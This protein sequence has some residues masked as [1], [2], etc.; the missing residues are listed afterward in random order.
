MWPC[1]STTCG[2]AARTVRQTPSTSTSKTRSHSS[3]EIGAP[4]PRSTA[5]CR[6]WPPPRR[7]RRSARPSR[8]PPPRSRAWSVTSAAIPIA[9]SP[10]RS[11]ASRASRGRGRRPRPRRPACASGARPRSRSPAPRRSPAPPFRSGRRAGM[12]RGSVLAPRISLPVPC[13]DSGPSIP[14]SPSPS[15]RRA[16]SRAGASATSSSA[17]W[18]TGMATRSGASTRGLPQPTAGPA[19][20]TSSPAS[21][22]T[23]IR[24]T[25]RCAATGCRARPAGTATASRRA[26]GREAARHLLEA[27]D[28]GLR[29]RR[30]QRALPGVRLRVR[31]GV[32]P[33]DRADR[34]LDRPRRPL[35]HPRQR[36][37]RVGLVV[38]AEAL[39]RRTASTRAT[40]SCPTARAAAPRSPPTRSPSDT[41]TSRTPLYTCASR[42]S[43]RAGT[44]GESL[45][46]WTTT[47]WTLPG[48][49]AVAVA[50]DVTY[51]K[52]AVEGETL[53]LA[54]PLVEQ[55]A[56]RGA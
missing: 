17:R 13:P 35:R 23:S 37:H 22:R 5:R 6:R 46:V 2:I 1:R 52:A 4:S 45:L 20:I 19:P 7:G 54:E 21:S 33:A 50:P 10:I 12:R 44:S 26:R 53:I 9:R 34:L 29:H 28:R 38:A 25:G 27:G 48:N 32:E 42:C 14:S 11:A 8:R 41:R 47:P 49:V 15:W 43:T 24:A 40:R 36:L 18:R 56:R 55:G 30:V 31:R 39:G 51:V 3:A 16:S